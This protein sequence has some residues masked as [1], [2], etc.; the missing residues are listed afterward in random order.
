MAETAAAWLG[1][2]MGVT[3]AGIDRLPDL[4]TRLAGG[5]QAWRAQVE[6]LTVYQPDLVEVFGEPTLLAA[7]I[8]MPAGF[9]R[10]CHA[11]RIAQMRDQPLPLP[12]SATVKLLGPRCARCLPALRE[13]AAARMPPKA[14]RRAAVRG[15]SATVSTSVA[16]GPSSC[17]VCE[18]SAAASRALTASGV[19]DRELS[20]LVARSHRPHELQPTRGARLVSVERRGGMLRT[21]YSTWDT[22]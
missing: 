4:L 1:G 5:V 14:R 15:K 18:L 7:A 9:C 13:A 19:E 2:Q 8:P 6:Q 11:I 17:R 22:Q 10:T 21:R 20:E 16:H 12:D 3:G